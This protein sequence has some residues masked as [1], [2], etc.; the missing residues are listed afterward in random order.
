MSAPV[1]AETF[2]QRAVL[3]L[4]IFIIAALP[5]GMA[6]YALVAD[7]QADGFGD[8]LELIAFLPGAAL[9]CAPGILLYTATLDVVADR[10]TLG[11]VICVLLTPLVV[12][13]WLAIT[14][15]GLVAWPVF[16]IGMGVALLAFGVL[17]SLARRAGWF[18]RSPRQA[19]GA[20]TA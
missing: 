18:V 11:L 17:V 20:P 7:T 10:I 14:G 15:V 5:L 1:R 6:A 19:D 2:W 13:P 12:L 4:V 9:M 3:H 16:P 8:V